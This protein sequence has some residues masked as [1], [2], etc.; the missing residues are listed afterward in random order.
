MSNLQ[1]SVETLKHFLGT[2][3][4]SAECYDLGTQSTIRNIFYLSSVDR[5]MLL[6]I[7]IVSSHFAGEN[8]TTK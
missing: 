6:T 5:F 1:K 3:F 2:S 4:N 8:Y 7:R